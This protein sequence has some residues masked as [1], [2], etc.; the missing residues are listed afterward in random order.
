M[1]TKFSHFNEVHRAGE[2]AARPPVRNH[3]ERLRAAGLRPTA[4][5][6]AV[7]QVF[8][9]ARGDALSSEDVY[10][11]LSSRGVQVSLGTAYRAAHD[12]TVHGLLRLQSTL[13]LKRMYRMVTASEAVE[14]SGAGLWAVNLASGERMRLAFDEELQRRLLAAVIDSGLNVTGGQVAVEFERVPSATRNARA[15]PRLYRV[16]SPEEPFEMKRGS[17]AAKRF[18]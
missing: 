5:R 16:R 15:S 4:P 12:L 2:G 11:R 18:C 6:I 3:V 13:G 1:S 14:E 10:K 17:K 9:E 7:L 8:E